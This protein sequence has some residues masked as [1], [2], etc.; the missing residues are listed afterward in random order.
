MNAKQA[1]TEELHGIVKHIQSLLPIGKY[2][3]TCCYCN[4]PWTLDFQRKTE[5]N[6]SSTFARKDYSRAHILKL[7]RFEH[8]ELMLYRAKYGRLK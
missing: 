5:K 3:T 7:L 4:Q 2:E 1:I 6:Y 8:S